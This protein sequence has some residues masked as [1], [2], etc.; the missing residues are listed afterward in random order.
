MLKCGYVGF[1]THALEEMEKDDLT[2][3]DCT[4]V[5]RGGVV[6]PGELEKGTYR[7]RVATRRISV[8]VA[9]RSD[10][11]LTVVTAWRTGN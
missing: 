9:F 10:E 1:T 4:N 8:V 5:M 7:Y 2:T 6:A 11:E 3:V